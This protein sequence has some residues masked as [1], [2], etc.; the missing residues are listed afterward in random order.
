MAIYWHVVLV[1]VVG[2]YQ[3]SVHLLTSLGSVILTTHEKHGGV[4]EK[5]SL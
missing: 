1:Y 2:W 3:S 5:F 4:L